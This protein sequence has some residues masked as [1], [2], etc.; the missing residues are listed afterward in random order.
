[1]ALRVGLP[2][3]VLLSSLAYATA[4]NAEMIGD[5]RYRAEVWF[6]DHVEPPASV[7][8]LT[9]GADRPSSSQ[10]LP[11]VHEL[12]YATYPV[13]ALPESFERPQP[14]YLI[15]ASYDHQD[16]GDSQKVCVEDLRAGKF[17]YTVVARFEKR[18]LGTGSSWLSSAG[19]GAPPPGKISPTITVFQSAFDRPPSP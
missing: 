14:E 4:V 9:N 17:G 13:V 8:A 2:C 6:T 10:Y 18:L 3:L 16:F 1:M 5:S 7:G 11:R 15:L 12:G 19:W